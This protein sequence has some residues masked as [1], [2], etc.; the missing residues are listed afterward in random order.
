VKSLTNR[1]IQP[2]GADMPPKFSWSVGLLPAVA[3]AGQIYGSLTTGREPAA[4]ARVEINC[5][6]A[7]TRAITSG[8]GSYR[9]AVPQQ[10]R[11][12]LTVPTFRGSPAVQ[13]V[14]YPNP[15]Q[16]DFDLIRRSDGN[17]ELR[18]R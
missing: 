9:A 16:Y 12:T 18:R 14:S 2:E 4:N 7:V 15:A 3:A 17:F 10:G 13:I 5:G 6:G 8:D 11:C 1:T